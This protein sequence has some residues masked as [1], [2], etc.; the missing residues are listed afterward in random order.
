M[1]V[2]TLMEMRDFSFNSRSRAAAAR[3]KRALW[4]VESAQG[5]SWAFSGCSGEV[6][7]GGLF[8]CRG[9]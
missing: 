8:G 9:C 7:F 6:E 2:A 4:I 3:V 5:V 1:Q